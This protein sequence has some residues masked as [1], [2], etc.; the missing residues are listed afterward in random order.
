V[1]RQPRDE[2]TQEAVRILADRTDWDPFHISIVLD[3]H[4][5]DVKCILE[6]DWGFRD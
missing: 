4:E 1:P 3:I 5:D 2:M 6:G